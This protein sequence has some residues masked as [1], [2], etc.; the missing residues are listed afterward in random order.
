MSYLSHFKLKEQP[1]RLTPDPE[2]VYWSK[3]HA[4]AKAYMESTIWLADG[5]VVITGEI[6]SGKTTL[7]QSFLAELDDDVIFAMVSQTQ[8]SPSQFLQAVLT[9]FGFKPF[10]QRKVELLDTL[11]MFLIEQY[12]QGKKVV[13]IVDEAQNLSKKVLEEIRLMSGIETHKEKVLRIILAGQPELKDTLDSPELKQL[14]QRIRLRFHVGPLDRREMREYIEHRLAVAGRPAKD[15]IK[16]DAYDAIYRYTGGVPRLIN[17]LCDTALLCAF[18]E[19][20]TVIGLTDVK[21]AVA[22]LNWKEHE[23]SAG[24]YPEKVSAAPQEKH[25]GHVTGIEVRSEGEL[26][27]R[28]F[29]GPGRVIV[30]RSPDNEIYIQ[31]KFVSRHHA[32][33]TNDE[34]GCV[35]EDLNSTNGVYIGSE[36]IKKYR[37]KDG[38]IVSLGIHELVYSDLR[39]PSAS[40][41]PTE[42]KERR[43]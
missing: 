17:T 36:R 30:G 32:Q 37:L 42:L 11:N 5:F 16:D 29:F 19:Q 21:A 15:L 39:Q 14:V 43:G 41:A 27:G 2:F 23:L 26:L 22:E 35:I 18:A 38:D 28:H 40:T 3:Q 8:L 33:L 7:L 6:G 1:F 25:P 10:N 20:K 31:S 4:R 34:S 13:L 9:E 12:A 24:S